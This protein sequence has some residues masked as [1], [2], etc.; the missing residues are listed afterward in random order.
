MYIYIYTELVPIE[1]CDKP[2]IGC[3][4]ALIVLVLICRGVYI[5]VEQPGSSK[6]FMVPYYKFIESMC[7]KFTIPIFNKFLPDT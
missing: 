7:K 3:R 5:F 1:F 6:L 4:T 2:R